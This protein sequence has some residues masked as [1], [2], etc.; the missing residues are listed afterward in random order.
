MIIKDV[1]DV[2]VKKITIK[3]VTIDE[4]D[5][6]DEYEQGAYIFKEEEY[7]KLMT[8]GYAYEIVVTS[9]R[10]MSGWFEDFDKIYDSNAYSEGNIDDATVWETG[11]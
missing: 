6:T 10:K 4:A 11:Q 2:V 5:K 1:Y 8:N 7:A 9:E 3:D